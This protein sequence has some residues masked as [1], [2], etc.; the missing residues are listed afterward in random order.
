MPTPTDMARQQEVIKQAA[1]VHPEVRSFIARAA[2]KSQRQVEH[3]PYYSRVRF[4]TTVV[5]GPP[6]TYAFTVK[7]QSLAFSYG[8][9]QD[10]GAAGFGGNIATIADTNIVEQSKTKD[11][12][13][14]SIYG[15]ASYV[16]PLSDPHLVAALFSVGS[17]AFVRQGGDIQKKIGPI[18]F[19]PSPGGLYGTG[20]SFAVQPNLQANSTPYGF[21]SNGLP[22]AGNFYRLPEEV[23]WSPS[24]E[25]DSTLQLAITAERAFTTSNLTPRTAGSAQGAIAAGALVD[26]FAPPTAADAPFTFVDLM[27][28]LLSRQVQ[29]RSQ[30]V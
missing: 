17:A 11:G 24:G 19:I 8:L 18:V 16:M 6:Q 2:L 5:A 20:Q 23:V 29:A 22:V 3:W 30:N 4:R 13:Q 25:Q 10:M 15:V 27:L 28:L 12:A 7:Q 21:V 9:G 1:S 26:I 14:L